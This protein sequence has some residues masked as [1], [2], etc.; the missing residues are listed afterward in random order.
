MRKG[1]AY[2]QFSTYERERYKEDSSFS[3]LLQ[4]NAMFVFLLLFDSLVF[5]PLLILVFHPH[6]K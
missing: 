5:V 4:R 2:L 6:F 1:R 3:Q